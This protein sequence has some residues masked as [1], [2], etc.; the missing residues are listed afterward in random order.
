MGPA[1]PGDLGDPTGPPFAL[2]PV[3]GVFIPGREAGALETQTCRGRKVVWF[4][5]SD[6][7]T[8]KYVHFRLL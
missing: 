2:L 5:V 7:G 8:R 1:G 4:T 6:A 3:E